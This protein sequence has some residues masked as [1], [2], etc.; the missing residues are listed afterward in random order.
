MMRHVMDSLLSRMDGRRGEPMVLGATPE[1]QPLR[2]RCEVL[3]AVP[4][5][6]GT[7]VPAGTTVHVE[8]PDAPDGAEFVLCRWDDS[9]RTVAYN[10]TGNATRPRWTFMEL[11]PDGVRLRVHWPHEG[12]PRQ[13]DFR[14]G[15]L[16]PVA[17]ATHARTL[18]GR[19]IRKRFL[20]RRRPWRLPA[21]EHK[22]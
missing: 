6:D 17:Q 5:P 9:R 1:G 14:W 20:R 15:G 4:A 8:I 19:P 21:K 18:R 16:L 12:A 3:P 7:S 13:Y 10:S 22:P 2:A 11:L